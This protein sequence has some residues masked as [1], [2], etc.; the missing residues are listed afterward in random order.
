MQTVSFVVTEGMLSH[1]RY[2]ST[3]GANAWAEGELQDTNLR[4]LSS[5]IAHYEEH[6]SADREVSW[7]GNFIY[8]S[9]YDGQRGTSSHCK[10]RGVTVLCENAAAR[11]VAL[12]LLKDW[13]KG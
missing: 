11:D 7:D 12:E 1:A 4:E 8:L 10:V 13:P 6:H 3:R 9:F 2:M 5:L